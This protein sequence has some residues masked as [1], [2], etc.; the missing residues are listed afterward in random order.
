MFPLCRYT[1]EVHRNKAYNFPMHMVEISLPYHVGIYVFNSA[2]EAKEFIAR[3][4]ADAENYGFE[5]L[6]DADSSI[7]AAPYF[8]NMTTLYSKLENHQIYGY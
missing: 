1:Y 7:I 5:M 3:E 6:Y 8:T 2:K 4:K